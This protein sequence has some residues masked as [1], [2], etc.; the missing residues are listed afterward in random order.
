[1]PNVWLLKV[2]ACI[3]VSNVTSKAMRF[4]DLVVALPNKVA[5][6]V[7]DGLSNPPAAAPYDALKADILEGTAISERK[8]LQL[9]LSAK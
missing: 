8:R 5:F 4:G 3:S 6:Q 9:L 1:R 2:E 7:Y